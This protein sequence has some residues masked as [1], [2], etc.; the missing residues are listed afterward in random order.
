MATRQSTPSFT[1]SASTNSAQR[2]GKSGNCMCSVR[3]LLVGFL[4]E[5]ARED[6]VMR[7][8]W[9]RTTM[10]MMTCD[11]CQLT[12]LLCNCWVSLHWFTEWKRLWLFF[13]CSRD[14]RWKRS[15][16]HQRMPQGWQRWGNS[17]VNWLISSIQ[18]TVRGQDDKWARRQAKDPE[19]DFDLN[20]TDCLSLHWLTKWWWCLMGKGASHQFNL[21]NLNQ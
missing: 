15:S 17:F 19:S 6:R 4:K 11:L 1:L 10:T 2:S 20:K 5:G 21:L 14:C 13:S 8:G 18:H 7:G 16:W 9:G 3:I 12:G